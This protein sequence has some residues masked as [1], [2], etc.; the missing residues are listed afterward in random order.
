MYGEG[1]QT[2]GGAHLRFG[3]ILFGLFMANIVFGVI[4]GRG[5]DRNFYSKVDEVQQG[6]PVHAY[7]NPNGKATND[8]LLSMYHNK[9]AGTNN[10]G[11]IQGSNVISSTFIQPEYRTNV[12]GKVNISESNPGNDGVIFA[13]RSGADIISPMVDEELAMRRAGKTPSKEFI[14]EKRRRQLEIRD[15]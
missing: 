9:T 8:P 11:M 13:R 5:K 15:S 2:G 10:T 14:E 7:Y 1:R 3:Y 4:T 12:P 6:K